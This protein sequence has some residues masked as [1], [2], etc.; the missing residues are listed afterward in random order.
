MTG[1]VEYGEW[2]EGS[3][4]QPETISVEACGGVVSPVTWSPQAPPAHPLPALSHQADKAISPYP[5]DTSP[6]AALLYS[7]IYYTLPQHSRLCPVSKQ[8]PFFHLNHSH[9]HFTKS[10]IDFPF[11]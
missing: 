7:S 9:N 8:L 1:C 11:L 3:M 4:V 10:P 2:D 6:P 5:P